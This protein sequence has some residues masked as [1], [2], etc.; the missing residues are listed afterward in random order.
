MFTLFIKSLIFYGIKQNR[1]LT[2][3][4]IFVVLILHTDLQFI[5]FIK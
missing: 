2:P 4:P 3:V 5:Y 1:H